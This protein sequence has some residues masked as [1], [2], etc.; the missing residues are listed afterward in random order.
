MLWSKACFPL[1]L[2]L[3]LGAGGAGQSCPGSL[4]T[5]HRNFLLQDAGL[6]DG[7]PGERAE[8]LPD[9]GEEETWTLPP[10]QERASK[11][12]RSLYWVCRYGKTARTVEIKVDPAATVCQ[13]QSSNSRVTGVCR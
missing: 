7:N 11:A 6:F 12:H 3:A 13:V 9:S 4:K 2:A 5:G 8:L 10:Y 1:A